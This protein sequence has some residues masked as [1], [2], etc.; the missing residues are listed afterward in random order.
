M[1]GSSTIQLATT[2]S[3]P[4]LITAMIDFVQDHEDP[5]SSNKGYGLIAAFA[6]NYTLLA[7]SFG[8]SAQS[9]AR[10][11]TKLRGCL[12][13]ALYETTLDTSSKDVDLGTATVLMNVDVEKLLQGCKQI[14]EIWAAFIVTG[15]ALYI[16][17]THLGVAFVAPFLTIIVSTAVSTWMGAAMRTRQGLYAATTER[18]ITAIAYVVANM[19]G[20]RMLGLSD[21][22]HQVLTQLRQA[23]VKAKVYIQNI[24]IWVLLLSN[25]MFQMTTVA[26]YVTFA[27]ITL[28]KGDG[29]ILDLNKLYGSLSALKLFT[30]PFGMVLQLLPIMQT[31]YASLERIE[32]FLM[33]EAPSTQEL[34]CLSSSAADEGTELLPLRVNVEEDQVISLDHA[35]F[36]INSQPLLLDLTANFPRNTMTMIFGRVGSGKSVLL[37]SLVGETNLSSGRFEQSLS[38]SAY[39]DQQVWLRNATVRENIVGEDPL[40]ES[41]YQKVIWSCGLLQDL[42]QMKQGDHT[43]IGSKGVSLSGGQKNRLSLARAV[44][45]R[46]PV[47]V[48]DDMLAGLDNTTEKLVFSR[49]FSRSGILRQ[50]GATVILATHATHYARYADQIIV[51]SGGRITEHGTYQDLVCRNVDFRKFNDAD[52]AS[53]P[54]N[55]EESHGLSEAETTVLVSDK[56]VEDDDE[57]DTA[58]QSGDRRSLVFFMKSIGP[59]HMTISCTTL[60]SA[61]AMTQV[62]YLWL[63]WWAEA[64]DQGRSA[65]IRQLYLFII[66]T[67][68]NI[69]AYLAYFAHYTFWFMPRLSL[70]MHASQLVA[71]MRAKFSFLASTVSERVSFLFTGLH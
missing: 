4:Y 14:N 66:V 27:V 60:V 69:A 63:K 49:V 5:K 9:M 39:C 1:T 12:I 10:F 61:I 22:V 29:S 11:L 62:Q 15:V 17:Y 37:R 2:I 54:E 43:A 23:E 3:Q 18:R 71:L 25:V 67:A 38:G 65:A 16:M 44:Y 26:T 20:V 30:T 32:N 21:T 48:I 34:F 52:D 57:Q 50:S 55:N 19:K 56:P 13:A 53:T 59:L 70:N 58:R 7:V 51:I 64:D 35:T 36:A 6:L 68:V 45:A 41:W 31:S 47:L 24:G 46:K 42:Q 28:T 40:D 33:R 8:W